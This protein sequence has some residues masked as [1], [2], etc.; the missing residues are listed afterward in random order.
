LALRVAV[1]EWAAAAHAARA[2][3]ETERARLDA[4]VRRAG[5]RLRALFEATVEL[6]VAST[7]E[8]VIE[9]LGSA[10]VGVGLNAHIATLVRDGAPDGMGL[11]IRYA[12]LTDRLLPT[13]ERLLGRSIAGIRLDGRGVAPYPVVLS[14]KRVVPVDDAAAWLRR[15]LPWLDVRAFRTIARLRGVG[16]GAC[17]PITDGQSVLGVLSVWGP[18]LTDA[19]LP[20]LG[21]LGYQAGTALASLGMRRAAAERAQLDG[22]VKTARLVAHELGNQLAIIIGYGEQLAAGLTGEQAE[23]AERV[24]AGAEAAGRIIARLQRIIRFEE[25]DVG[26]GP[27]LDLVAAT[28]PPLE[29]PL[30]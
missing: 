17:A 1:A 4:E 10:V 26:G 14:E 23:H 8:R 19:D 9:L 28:D 3:V 18:A 15:A 12:A 25:T 30:G 22:A 6:H 29:R 11:E 20:T 7:E 21:L 24:V 16:Q 5:A 27:M 13:V 2:Q